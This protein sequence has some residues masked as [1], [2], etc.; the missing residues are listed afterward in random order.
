MPIPVLDKLFSQ[1]AYDLETYG[2]TFQGVAI[3][4]QCA[5]TINQPPG[6]DSPAASVASAPPPVLLQYAPS[7]TETIHLPDGIKLTRITP[8][9]FSGGAP[10]IQI[11]AP[12]PDVFPPTAAHY[13]IDVFGTSFI[14]ETPAA[15]DNTAIVYGPALSSA[16]GSAFFTLSLSGYS[17]VGYWG[18]LPPVPLPD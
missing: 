3:S 10:A 8:A 9:S 6:L 16:P 14:P 13:T 18:S 5:V 4:V 12:Q 11:L 7:T 2:F 15:A 1:A 17:A